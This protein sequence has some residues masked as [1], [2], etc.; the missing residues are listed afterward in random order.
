MRE[1]RA[2]APFSRIGIVTG[3]LFVR[4]VAVYQCHLLWRYSTPYETI[5]RCD[6]GWFVYHRRHLEMNLMCSESSAIFENINIEIE[7]FLEHALSRI[8]QLFSLPFSFSFFVLF[9]V[10]CRIF[11][12][13]CGNLAAKTVCSKRE[14]WCGLHLYWYHINYISINFTLG[15]NNVKRKRQVV[16]EVRSLS[17]SQCDTM[18]TWFVFE[19][20]LNFL[21][22]SHEVCISC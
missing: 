6:F 15:Q 13:F 11:L 8:F 21:S 17:D 19:N 3:I 1:C 9:F 2:S 18:E 12:P 4:S 16:P 20:V 7:V 22:T 10:R 5:D 14:R